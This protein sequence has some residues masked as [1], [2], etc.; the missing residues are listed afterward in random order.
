V[1][2]RASSPVAACILAGALACASRAHAQPEGDDDGELAVTVRGAST[3]AFTARASA[4]TAVREPKD[5]ASLVAELPGVHVRRLGAEG[6][7]ATMSIRGS[8]ST[9]VGVMLGGIPLTSAADPSLDVGA[10]PLWPGATLRVYRGFAPA[11]LGTTGYL[12]GVLAIDPPSPALGEKTEVW[13]LGGSFGT[14]KLRVGDLRRTGSVT[15]GTALF[16]SRTDGDFTYKVDDPRANHALEQTRTNARVVTAGGLERVTLERAW[17]SVGATLFGD[18]R[19]QGLPG[20]VA[21]PTRAARLAQSRLVVGVDAL[22]RTGVV[23]AVHAAAWGRREASRFNDPLGEID[24]RRPDASDAIVAAGGSLG[25][26]GRPVPSVTLDVLTDA[27]GER[28]DPGPGAT[29]MIQA[30]RL[31]AGAGLDVEWRPSSRV[32]LSGAGRVDAL[33]DEATA[34][35]E[36]DEP[37]SRGVAPTGHV[38]ASVRVLGEALVIAA[39]AGA[40]ERPPGFVELYGNLGQLMGEPSLRSERALSL[41]W[42]ASGQ[43]GGRHIRLDYELVGFAT[44][45]RDL[46]AFVPVGIGTL[47]ARNLDRATLLGA[48]ASASL[49]ARAVELRASYTLLSTRNEGADPLERGRPLPSRPVHDLVYDAL[50]RVGPLRLRYGLDVVGGSTIDT[51]GAI[52][53]P[54]RVLHGAGIAA[55]LPWAPTVRL[56]LEIDNL[57][58]LRELHPVAAAPLA[59]RAVGVPVSDLL[60]YPLPGRTI[61]ASLRVVM[62]E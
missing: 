53:L 11:A 54:T 26:R 46:I 1:S 33:R 15:T 51:R 47:R 40:L 8:A 30:R 56:G 2:R 5:A 18:A 61:W 7:Y 41:D 37:S 50:Y 17:G 34:A 35:H 28:F 20:S 39:H 27:R 19:Q 59:T 52:E 4:D 9:Q 43:L 12:G 6:S 38:G 32:A 60:G 25:W 36:R 62:P 3:A 29:R 58:D 16:A 31:A 22:V 14:L 44:S 13:L 57:L 23:G 21:Q 24:R 45:A 55:T 42:G 10:L 48:E 49:R